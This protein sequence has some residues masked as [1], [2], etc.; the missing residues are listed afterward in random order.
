MTCLSSLLKFTFDIND[1]KLHTILF[2]YFYFLSLLFQ[3]RSNTLHESMSRASLHFILSRH[4][5]FHSVNANLK[6]TSKYENGQTAQQKF[7][8]VYLIYRNQW[9]TLPLATSGEMSE[10]CRVSRIGLEQHP[11]RWRE[12][13][14]EKEEEEEEEERREQK[15]RNSWMGERRKRPHIEPVYRRRRARKEGRC[16]E[17]KIKEKRPESLRENR[18]A[19]WHVGNPGEHDGAIGAPPI[20]SRIR[21]HET[22]HV[23]ELFDSA[24]QDSSNTYRVLTHMQISSTPKFTLWQRC[25]RYK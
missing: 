16:A 24:N 14:V 15:K 13:E 19:R 22:R 9:S 18:V 7:F 25:Q 4:V 12:E 11:A 21:A 2:V 1:I 8:G 6:L 5:R 17:E 20:L 23:L 10:S 3:R